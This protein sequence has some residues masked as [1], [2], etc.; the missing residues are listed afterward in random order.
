M[1]DDELLHCFMWELSHLMR[2]YNASIFVDDEGR[3]DFEL[4]PTGG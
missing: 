2:K 3:I 1:N 4:L